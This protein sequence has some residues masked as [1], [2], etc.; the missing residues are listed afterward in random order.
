MSLAVRTKVD[1]MALVQPLRS[2]IRGALNDQVLYD[3]HTLEE[4]DAASLGRQ[5]F[6]MLLF[7][8]FATLALLLAS[9][10]IYGVLAYL[11]RQRVPEIGIRMALGASAG[12][13]MWMVL[14]HS[15]AMVLTG[16]FAGAL[17]SIAAI[18]L[19]V[20]LVEGVRSADPATFAWPILVL[21]IAAAIAS[22]LPARHA[23]RIDPMQALRQ[24]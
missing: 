16:V 22:F 3:V 24:D 21:I 9:I 19:L 12:E 8:M 2:E 23:S 18:G 4:L 20:R 1:P 15:F 6:L 11:T 5:R 17:A 13:V 10:G 7:G 14:R